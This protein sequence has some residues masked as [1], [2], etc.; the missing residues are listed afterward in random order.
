[1]ALK[2]LY[3][4]NTDD[5]KGFRSKPYHGSNI[6]G[7]PRRSSLCHLF[8]NQEL[9]SKV[10]VAHLFLLIPQRARAPKHRLTWKLAG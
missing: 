10:E 5:R 3:S 2:E 7:S 8:M 9:F 1:M 4:T 6:K